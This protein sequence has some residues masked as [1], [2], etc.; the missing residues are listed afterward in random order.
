MDDLL[1]IRDN[2]AIHRVYYDL[3]E[4]VLSQFKQLTGREGPREGREGLGSAQRQHLVD[5]GEKWRDG[6]SEEEYPG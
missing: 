1:Y 2:C 4:P 3:F 5:T 6:T